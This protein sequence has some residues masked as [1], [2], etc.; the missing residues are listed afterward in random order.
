LT[1]IVIL[2]GGL[3]N[4][5][6]QV[7]AA[8]SL[9]RESN[10]L[11]ETA[12]IGSR[13][14]LGEKQPIQEFNWPQN[15]RFSR[16]M[17]FHKLSRVIIKYLLSHSVSRQSRK[18][19]LRSRF[20]VNAIRPYFFFLYGIFIKIE[21]GD[22]LKFSTVESGIRH[23]ILIGYFQ[24][25]EYQNEFFF[26][27]LNLDPSVNAE[28]IQFIDSVRKVKPVIVHVRLGDYLNEPKIGVP[29]PAYYI[30]GVELIKKN[31][32]EK[33]PV[34]ILSDDIG[35][36]KNYLHGKEFMGCTWIESSMYSPAVVITALRGAAGFVISNSTFSWWAAYARENTKAAVIAPYP[37]FM[38]LKEPDDLIPMDWIR[39]PANFKEGIHCEV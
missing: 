30:E 37:W 17:R 36:A 24:S 13:S 12:F 5:L 38:Q 3:G 26:P 18:S 27:K 9:S 19:S 34:W 31:G 2:S 6:F 21:L 33:H 8:L 39:L 16:N 15:V 10:L 11:I 20:V 7:N 25:C 4:Q 23:R 32:L 28:D 1:N 29:S 22:R 35:G 14:V